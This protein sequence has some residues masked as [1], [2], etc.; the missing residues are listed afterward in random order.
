MI[1]TIEGR[2]PAGVLDATA[3]PVIVILT[4][5]QENASS[6]FNRQSL[7]DLIS[8][9]RQ[10]GWTF[11]FMGANQD[12]ISVG[13]S[14]GL[15]QGT[16]V[17]YLATPP[18]QEAA[19]SSCSAQVSRVRSGKADGGFSPAERM[20]C[21]PSMGSR[22]APAAGANTMFGAPAPAFGA[23]AFGTSATAPFKFGGSTPAFGAPA[24]FGGS[25][26]SFGSSA[27]AP[28]STYA[29]APFGGSA[30]AFGAPAT[31]F[32]TFA[33]AP[34]GGSAAA[35]GA[36]AFG[37]P[38]FG[39]PAF[40]APAFGAPAFGAPAFGAPAFGGSARAPGSPICTG[41]GLTPATSALRLGSADMLY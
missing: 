10:L 27:P 31:A 29:P 2:V 37:A 17:T 23:P 22:S 9:K 36:P 24:A 41:T 19:W 30:T 34:F 7:F 1:Q 18:S 32:G 16:C 39:A 15:P 3:A 8:A 28:F 12:A 13:G 35:F 38:A 25:A 14:I 21:S 33:P 4:D 5:G 11:T 20:S 6:K 40:G 26:P